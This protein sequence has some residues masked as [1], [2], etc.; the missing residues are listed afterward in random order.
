MHLVAGKENPELLRVMQHDL[1]HRHRLP[2]KGPMMTTTSCHPNHGRLLNFLHCIHL[3]HL[4]HLIAGKQN[5]DL[6]R[7]IQ[8]DLQHHPHM[9]PQQPLQLLCGWT[10][11]R[12]YHRSLEDFH[13]LS[14]GHRTLKGGTDNQIGRGSFLSRYLYRD[15]V[16]YYLVI[17]IVT[18]S[19]ASIY[20]IQ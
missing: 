13:H 6:L 7:V 16:C 12:P 9:Y 17:C 20:P 5:L 14:V 4:I 2:L 19:F 3:I 18:L 11:F 8:Y 10:P 1:H 15:I